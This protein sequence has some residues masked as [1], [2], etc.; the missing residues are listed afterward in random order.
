MFV[1]FISKYLKDFLSGPAS[2]KCR[3]YLLISDHIQ[4]L[5]KEGLGKYPSISNIRDNVDLIISDMLAVLSSGESASGS[6][7][8]QVIHG[9]KTI[10]KLEGLEEGFRLQILNLVVP[11]IKVNSYEIF[12]EVVWELMQ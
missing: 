1:A 6:L 4:T 9:L 3:F 5:A 10:I 7:V 11:Q 2:L 12:S 8:Y